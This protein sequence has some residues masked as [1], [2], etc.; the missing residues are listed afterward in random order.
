[1]SRK[2]KGGRKEEGVWK[3]RARGKA[4]HQRL[5]SSGSAKWRGQ[6]PLERRFGGGT[7]AGGKKRI[8][9]QKERNRDRWISHQASG[10]KETIMCHP[11]KQGEEAPLSGKSFAEFNGFTKDNVWNVGDPQNSS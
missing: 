7:G 4:Q 5:I 10:R 8:T 11:G 3:I 6:N 2:V 1:M 9:L